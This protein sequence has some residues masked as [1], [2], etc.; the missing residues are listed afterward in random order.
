M[1]ITTHSWCDVFGIHAEL[2]KA[3]AEV[4]SCKYFCIVHFVDK[5]VNKGEGEPVR[6]CLGVEASVVDDDSEFAIFL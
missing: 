6:L 3:V 4:Q 2:I 1:G 5:D